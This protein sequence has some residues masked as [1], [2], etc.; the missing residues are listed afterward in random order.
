MSPI[1]PDVHCTADGEICQF[2]TGAS[3]INAAGTVAAVA[4]NDQFNFTKTYFIILG[5]A[6]VNPKFA[7]G[8]SVGVA[9]YAIQNA[10]QY[11]FDIRDLNSSFSSGYIPLGANEPAPAQYPVNIYGTEVF[12][13]NK[14]L[15][16]KAFYLASLATL[17]DS[18]DSMAYRALYPNAPANQPPKVVMADVLCSDVYF[19]GTVS[20]ILVNPI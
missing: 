19:S 4:M 12:E 14:A 13:V 3:E 18:S 15:Q 9:R 17:N 1:Y 8:G 20:F 5:I 16:E 6:G 10:L 7:T 2:T 11:E